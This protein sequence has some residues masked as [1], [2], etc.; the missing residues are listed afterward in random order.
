M[1]G[2]LK[3]KENYN[4]KM[5]MIFEVAKTELKNLFYSPIAWFLMIV[6]FIQCAMVYTNMLDN[7]ATTQELGGRNLDYMSQLTY[8]IFTGRG[9]LFNNVMQ[10]L[11]LYI[12]LLTMGLISRE[13][14]AG[15]IKLLYSSPIKVSEIVFGKYVAMMAYSLIL[16][17]IVGVFMVAGMFNIVAVD[18]GMLLSAA[19]GFFLLLCA[20]SAIGLFMSCLT[21]YQVVAAVSTFVM[22]GILSYIGTLWQQYDF[23]RDI[24]YFLSLSDR[25]NHMLGGL[26]TTKDIIYFLII[27]Y[28]FL[29]FS[30]YKLKGAR[31]SKPV[32][33]KAGRYAFIVVSALA[34]GYITSLP[35]L[36][37]YW[38]TTFSKNNTLTSNAQKIIHELGKDQLEVI[39]YNNLIENHAYLGMPEIRNRY[40]SVWEPYVRFK[41]DIAFSYVM[42][43]DNPIEDKWL[44]KSYPGKSM[45]EIAGLTAK[46][47]KMDLDR[48]KSPEEIHKTINLE[49]EL[50][51]FV[52]QLKYK[53]RTTFLRIFNDQQVFPG[54]TEV[55]AAFKRLLGA[56]VPRVAF[57]TGDLERSV[58]K[59]GDREYKTLTKLK[60]FRYALINQGFDVD[61]LTLEG[62]DVPEWVSTL[63][64]ADPKTNLSPEAFSKIQGY[65]NKGGNLLI[66]GEP[67]KQAILNPL[68]KQFNVQL[69]EGSI[70]QPSADL[71]P[72]LVLND[73]TSTSAGF[74]KDV[75]KGLVDSLPVAMSGATGLSYTADGLFQIKPLLMT[76]KKKSWIKKGKLVADSAA[77]VFSEA[78]GD[79]RISVPTALSLTR[80][81]N[82]KEQRIVVT[83]DADLMSNAELGRYNV[84][85]ANF[86]F[87]TAL[88]S[89]LNYGEFPVDTSRPAGKD[90]RVKVTSAQVG[91]LNILFVW[92][93][94]AI[95]LALGTVLLIRRKRK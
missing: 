2:P 87:N 30:I 53:G 43:Y 91:Q 94:P 54:E 69:M 24:T 52:M 50:N 63:V 60:S 84:K 11:Y 16:V 47:F 45:K 77:V 78:A 61:T 73:L 7:N 64:I 26:I 1:V 49:P 75:A 15:T 70:A 79:Q 17:A 86:A 41:P 46:S 9:G 35:A 95:L 80:K 83:G 88:F 58:G 21:T 48:F 82:G 76:D 90:N 8:R 14:N 10:N 23:V 39:V 31:E 51:R 32:V 20:Y 72:D 29:G 27:V 92:I 65:I 68:L 81:I 19:L 40:L 3:I 25:T 5:K 42:Y 22:I 38:D 74:T 34:I 67:G 37:G 36:I 66:M 12:P 18:S 6:F 89:W 44:F 56:K 55:S 33:V 85:T 57:L 13:I 28:I 93:L 4:N 62:G 71:A 59:T